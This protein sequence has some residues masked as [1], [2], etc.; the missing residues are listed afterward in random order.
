MK[1]KQ[2]TYYKPVPK[3]TGILYNPKSGRYMAR[4]KVKGID[5]KETFDSLYDARVWKAT[6]DGEK[7]AVKATSTV[8]LKEVWEEMQLRHFPIIAKST[9]EIW[10]R[11][12]ELLRELEF[13]RMEEITSSVITS[14]VE[15]HVKYFKSEAYLNSTRGEAKRCNLD[16]ELNLF[17]TIFNW[18]K[19]SEAYEVEAMHLPNPVRISHKRLGF[20][21][22]KPV[23]NKAITLDAALKFFSCLKPLYRDLALFQFYSASR[24]S[25]AAGLQWS[26]IDF[27]NRTITI[28]ETSRWDSSNKTFIELNPFPKNREPRTV[29]MTNELCELLKRRL[30]F[31]SQENDFV[32]QVEGIPLNYCTIQLHYR[33]AQRIADIPYRGTHILR[34]GMAKLAR[35]VGGGLDAVV[36]MT[37]HKDYKLADHYSKLDIEYQKEVSLKIMD[38]IN[39]Q[40][41]TDIDMSNVL[42]IAKLARSR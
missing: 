31:K 4:K 23:R 6:F 9:Q 16:N 14:W 18:Y 28:M 11:R 38:H 40:S 27:E 19:R 26:R 29:F 3:Q 32:F 42:S 12:Y 20:I 36:A 21:R 10:S 7:S 1:Q 41:K 5:Y 8:T 13:L 34:H 17:T 2:K 39:G 37:G 24:I 33:E 35:K 30:A 25:E 22:P 15:K